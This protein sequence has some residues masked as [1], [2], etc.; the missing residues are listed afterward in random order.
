MGCSKNSSYPGLQQKKSGDLYRRPVPSEL[1]PMQI[2]EPTE[3]VCIKTEKIYESCKQVETNEEIT[4][5]CGTAKGEIMDVWCIDTELVIDEHHLFRCEKI[6]N[7]QRARVSFWFRFRFAYVDQAGQ[8]FHTSKPIF[9]EKMVI[10][11]DQIFDRRLYVQCEVF[12]DCFECFVSGPQQVTCC[13]G[14]LLLVKLVAMVQL[15]VPAY[16]FCPDPDSCTEVEAECP[17]FEPVWPPFPP[18]LV[19]VNGDNNN[20]TGNGGGNG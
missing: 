18:Q 5:L 20:D 9:F 19:Q 7:T 12:L 2:P 4:N 3:V 13:I 1:K 15:L 16:G 8:K 11:S 6:P 10:L 17:P 14:K